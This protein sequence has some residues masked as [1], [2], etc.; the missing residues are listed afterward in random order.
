MTRHASKVASTRVEAERGGDWRHASACRDE[1]PEL[2]H[3]VGTSGPAL[4]QVEQARAVCHRCPVRDQC[5]TWALDHMEFGVA[6]GLSEDER[7]T[8]KR[9]GGVNALWGTA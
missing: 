4:L 8:L 1:D 7:R 6:G 5:L 9:L 2:F 3:P